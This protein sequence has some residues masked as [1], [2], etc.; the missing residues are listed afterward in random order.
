MGVGEQPDD[1][2]RWCTG[3]HLALYCKCGYVFLAMLPT[4]APRT[5]AAARGGLGQVRVAW[6]QGRLVL[7]YERWKR[8][9]RTSSPPARS[10]WTAASIGLRHPR[11]FEDRETCPQT[12]RSWSPKPDESRPCWN[13][14]VRPHG[15]AEGR[16]G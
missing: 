5:W 14:Q 4:R 6:P 3:M 10:C 9:P 8:T 2:P 11:T 12:R 7:Q 1:R 16:G 13:R 15:S